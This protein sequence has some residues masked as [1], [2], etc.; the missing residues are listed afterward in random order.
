MLH[1]YPFI[2][3]IDPFKC[4]KCDIFGQ[5]I[6]SHR[7]LADF[8][9]ETWDARAAPW[10]WLS[11]TWRS[12]ASLGAEFGAKNGPG[13]QITTTV[14][15]WVYYGYSGYMMGILWVYYGYMIRYDKYIMGYH[16]LQW[17]MEVNFGTTEACSPPG[18]MVKKRNHPKMAY[19]RLVN[20]Y[21]L[22]S[23]CPDQICIY[24]YTHLEIDRQI[25]RRRVLKEVQIE[26]II[27]YIQ[28]YY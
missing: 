22:V 6:F 20:Y 4:Y 26:T 18:I 16:T 5:L 10:I 13:F 7:N 9:Q 8:R 15:L 12:T 27:N 3:F 17:I 24:I 21:E 2:I 14:T 11:N 23:I 1:I 25:D 19:V 28:R